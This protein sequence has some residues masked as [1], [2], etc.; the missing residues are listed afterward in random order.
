MNND[1]TEELE[2]TLDERLAKYGLS[3]LD[4]A[5]NNKS[6]IPVEDMFKEGFKVYKGGNRQRYMLRMMERL[7]AINRATVPLPIIRK[8]CWEQN[9]IIFEVPL[10]EKEFNNKW[11]EAVRYINLKNGEYTDE[12]KELI[13]EIKDLNVDLMAYDPEFQKLYI[14]VQKLGNNLDKF[15]RLSSDKYVEPAEK[16]LRVKVT[17]KHL[18]IQKRFFVIMIKKESMRCVGNRR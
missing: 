10:D 1:N 4:K 12:E 16:K 13:K 2:R 14:E 3:Y 8:W 9:Q 17:S 7:I 15:K 18:P 6:D 5:K 11:K